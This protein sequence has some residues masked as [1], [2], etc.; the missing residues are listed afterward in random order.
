MTPTLPQTTIHGNELSDHVLAIA[1]R[2]LTLQSLGPWRLDVCYCH[3]KSL[4]WSEDWKEQSTVFWLHSSFKALD[5]I[6]IFGTN[7]SARQGREYSHR[8]HLTP[9]ATT[10]AIENHFTIDLCLH[11]Q[12]SGSLQIPSAA[13]QITRSTA[14]KVSISS[15]HDSTET[16][17]TVDMSVPVGPVHIG[18]DGNVFQKS[19]S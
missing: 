4:L 17:D 14:S 7:L 5:L 15:I 11:H 10:I 6:V 2:C 3:V 13:P 12:L 8:Q 18:G 16:G 19:S 1:D 9:R